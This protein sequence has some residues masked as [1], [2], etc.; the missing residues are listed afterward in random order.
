MAEAESCRMSLL[1]VTA[2]AAENLMT[3][4]PS[5]RSQPSAPRGLRHRQQQ[6]AAAEALYSRSSRQQLAAAADSRAEAQYSRRYLQLLAEAWYSLH[7][8]PQQQVL[9]QSPHRC[10]PNTASQ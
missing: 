10:R 3:A 5:Q 4:G 9:P 7:C 6:L 1:R 8:R 2:V